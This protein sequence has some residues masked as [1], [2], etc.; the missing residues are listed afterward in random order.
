LAKNDPVPLELPVYQ[1]CD[2]P[3]ITRNANTKD[4]DIQRAICNHAASHQIQTDFVDAEP[5]GLCCG[6]TCNLEVDITDN[7]KTTI[8]EG[9]K[10]SPKVIVHHQWD[11]FF[12][13]EPFAYKFCKPKV[14]YPCTNM[15]VL[16]HGC[17]FI[18]F[19]W[20]YNIE[21]HYKQNHAELTQDDRIL[22]KGHFLSEDEKEAVTMSNKI[23]IK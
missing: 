16:Y 2:P 20:S 12:D 19:I 18:H 22:Y 15:L 1:L 5:C 11:T 14:G 21:N 9:G 7:T 8:Y 17:N 23:N 3:K 10:M 13:L 4:Y 6:S